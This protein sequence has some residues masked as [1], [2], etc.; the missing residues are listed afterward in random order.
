MTLSTHQAP[1]CAHH[2]GPQS[3]SFP[4]KGSRRAETP[5]R[6]TTSTSR[7]S[8]QT[9]DERELGA[10][11]RCR[12]SPHP[13]CGDGPTSPLFDLSGQG[14][15]GHWRHSSERRPPN[16][17][18]MLSPF[19]ADYIKGRADVKGSTATVYSH[20]QRCLIEYFGADRSLDSI[21]PADADVGSAGWLQR[22][23]TGRASARV[24]RRTPSGGAA[25]SRGSSF[26]ERSASALSWRIRLLK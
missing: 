12:P 21:S 24:S 2:R 15:M 10:C 6:N 1:A 20:T 18:S 9:I 3:D 25:A 5:G 14:Q 16:P 4:V 19:L 13:R 11:R 26:A 8:R 22:K 17:L 7:R 23:T